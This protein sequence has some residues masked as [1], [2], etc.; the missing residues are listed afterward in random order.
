MGLGSLW[1][2]SAANG[3]AAIVATEPRKLRRLKVEESFK[4]SGMEAFLWLEVVWNHLW[5]K[6][7]RAFAAPVETR[8]L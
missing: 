6:G 5:Q 4:R 1:A 3:I 7:S 8:S 2:R